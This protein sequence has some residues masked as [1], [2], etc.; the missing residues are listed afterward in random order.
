MATGDNPHLACPLLIA[1]QVTHS[2]GM[3]MALVNV[4]LAAGHTHPRACP[5]HTN[6]LSK[7]T[8]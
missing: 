5:K 1:D 4:I 2:I 7:S 8:H 3:M 6:G